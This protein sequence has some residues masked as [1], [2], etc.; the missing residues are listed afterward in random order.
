[1]CLLEHGHVRVGRIPHLGF[2]SDGHM[3]AHGLLEV[4]VQS[5]FRIG[6]W[7]VAGQVKHFDLICSFSQPSFHM[8]PVMYVEVVQDGKDFFA[9]ILEQGFQEL[10]QTVTFP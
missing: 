9:C 6:L 3:L 4:G 10:D 8:L 2:G 5:L 7:A 1:M